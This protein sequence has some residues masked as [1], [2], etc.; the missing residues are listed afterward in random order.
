M[1]KAP[2][3]SPFLAVLL[4]AC[5]SEGWE[6]GD[7]VG[8][9]LLD[10]AGL[11]IAESRQAAWDDSPESRWLIDPVP[12]LQVGSADDS[13]FARVYS[14]GAALRL[15]DGRIVV[16]GQRHTI[17][18]YSDRGEYLFERGREGDG[19]GEFRYI[20]QMLHLWP[21]SVA[22]YNEGRRSWTLFDGKG[23]SRTVTLSAL[24]CN[25]V[26][27]DRSPDGRWLGWCDQQ[28]RV[29]NSSKA[30]GTG[31]QGLAFS[32]SGR[33]SARSEAT[34]HS[35]LIAISPDGTRLDTLLVVE[36]PG[37]GMLRG[38]PLVA[39]VGRRIALGEARDH[40]LVLLDE[41]WNP[42]RSIRWMG[43]DLTIPPSEEAAWRESLMAERGIREGIASAL[44][45]SRAETSTRESLARNAFAA[46]K[47]AYLGLFPDPDGAIW[48]RL[49]T[50]RH[51]P[52]VFTVIGPDGRYLGDVRMP[53][54][55]HLTQV[56]R[57]FVLGL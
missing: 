53:P 43:E 39:R 32:Q 7:R 1:C 13:I 9:S 40:S 5:G 38:F 17:L 47:G 25:L 23:G 55:F 56:G 51:E 44:D 11:T 10:S 57:D 19:P 34:A 24:D 8:F 18:W 45:P 35:S 15:D 37:T 4:L 12:L 30:G 6:P 36:R 26:R 31:S 46:R 29:G 33:S 21:D 54:D 20:A 50:F 49:N 52:E 3:L 41:T 27:R 48:I 42:V 2:R 22:V 28:A 16:A 14:V